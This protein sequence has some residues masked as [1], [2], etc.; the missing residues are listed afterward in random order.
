MK[1]VD[2]FFRALENLRGRRHEGATR[3]KVLF[4]DWRQ[5]SLAALDGKDAD[6]ANRRRKSSVEVK[7]QNGG[8][9]SRS[10]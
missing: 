1:K 3:P 2:N 10:P 6:L 9:S 4:V 5:R 8:R 7:N